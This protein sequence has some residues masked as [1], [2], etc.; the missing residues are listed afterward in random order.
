[1]TKD[2]KLVES[3]SPEVFIKVW[4]GIFRGKK[5]TPDVVRT[6]CSGRVSLKDGDVRNLYDESNKAASPPA[7]AKES[8]N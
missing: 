5:L 2:G 1:M 3:L 7:P 8:K 4:N 6:Y